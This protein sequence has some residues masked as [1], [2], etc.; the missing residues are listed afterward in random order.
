MSKL[1]EAY[2]YVKA[3]AAEGRV[4]LFVVQKP[5][6]S[7]LLKKKLND[8]EVLT[9]IFAG[10]VAVNKFR[11]G[12]QSIARMKTFEEIAGKGQKYEGVLKRKP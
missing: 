11:N 5:K 6:F 1:K 4:P 10:S 2:E 9:S 12:K 8:A 3:S 7:E